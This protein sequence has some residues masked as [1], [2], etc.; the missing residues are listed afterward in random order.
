[1]IDSI[2]I[3]TDPTLE[4]VFSY[5]LV[6]CLDGNLTPDPR[7]WVSINHQTLSAGRL[8]IYSVALTKMG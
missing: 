4:L 6:R 5:S 3:G 2:P 7:I 8:S 1:M